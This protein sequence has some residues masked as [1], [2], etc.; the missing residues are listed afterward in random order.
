MLKSKKNVFCDHMAIKNNINKKT[1]DV[2]Y[3]Q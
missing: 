3:K 1:N 2:S